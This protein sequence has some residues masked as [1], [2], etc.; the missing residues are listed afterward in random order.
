MPKTSSPSLR[1]LRGALAGLALV[2]LAPAA[3]ATPRALAPRAAVVKHTGHELAAGTPVERL[4]VKFHEGSRVRLRDN[5]LVALVSERSSSE[6]SLF[7][8][9]GM[10]EARLT[11]DLRSVEALLDRAP[12][13]RRPQ[14]LL[15]EDEA[16]LEARKASGEALSGEQLAD[17]NLYFQVP[18]LP[19]TTSE[20]VADVVA[21]LNA[22]DTV[23]VAYA[24]PP[25]ED[26]TVNTGLDAAL[27]GV[28]AAVDLPP[29]TPL[30]TANQ[31][32]L[33]VAPGG[34]DANYAWTVAGGTGT[35][36]RI[37][38]VETGWN[39]SHEDMPALFYVGAAGT[40]SDHGTAVLG[41]LV[42]VNNAYGMKGIAYG[43]Q[44]GVES[45][46]PQGLSSALSKAVTAAGP[47]GIV[48]VEV[49]SLGPND[50]TACTCNTSQCHYIAVEY[51][52]APY[53]IIR[54]ATANGVIVVEAAGNG[55]AN[56]D[57]AAYAG[58]FNRATRDS[59]AIIVGASTAT[60]RAPMCWTNFGGRVDVHGW[61]ERVA[62][63]GYGTLFGSAHG[64]NQYYTATFS[65][66]SSASPI[67]TGAAASAQGVARANGRLLTSVQMRG[68]L[69]N[70][71]TAQ[72]V[73]TR[74]IGPLPDLRK[75]LPKVISG[76]Y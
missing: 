40:V 54:N 7:F 38:D 70:N 33:N 71:G 49:H 10:S 27:R 42:A 62:S 11:E 39:R 53:D 21:A 60:T 44:M 9:R 13:T 52:Q 57:A 59:G 64:V 3:G 67:V 48:L 2:A 35:G 58:R 23:E 65:G 24:E 15:Q 34:I 47:G 45:H 18:L 68:L 4:V 26:A 50:G 16:T 17:L 61:G 46:T 63:L 19:G 25:V 76:N 55:S 28:L 30:Y 69:R 36:V 75:M 20:R 8:G 22:L 29:T 5:A 72:A 32:Y 1:P 66:T 51:W 43:A 14:R 73:D 6:R 74:Q 12:R 41:E 37:V 31:G 56:L